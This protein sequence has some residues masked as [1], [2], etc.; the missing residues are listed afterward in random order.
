MNTFI[1]IF[2]RQ[3]SGSVLL[4]ALAF[5][6]ERRNA[7][8][9]LLWLSTKLFLYAPLGY[10]ITLNVTNVGL[11]YTSSTVQ[12]ATANSVP[13]ATFFL[14]VLLRR[15]RSS[16]LDEFVALD[17]GLTLQEAI[18]LRSLSGVAK[19]AG[20][21]LCLAGVLVIAFYTG[22]GIGPVNHHRL[23][24]GG[25]QEH[26]AAENGKGTNWILGTFLMVLST[27]TWSLWTVLM[28]SLLKEYPSTL[29]TTALQCA[30][31][32]V[33]PLPL[34][35]AVERDPAAWRL[36]FDSGLLAI[37]YTG[38][39]ATAVSLYM[40]TWCI[41][42]KGPVFLAMSYPLGFVFTLFCSSFILG[43]V[44]H[45]GSVV[46]GV[47]MV[48]GLYSVLWG[49]SKEND[50]AKLTTVMVSSAV[51]QEET[52]VAPAS[53]RQQQPLQVG[54]VPATMDAKKP[55]VI[56][57]VIQVIFTGQYVVSKAAFDHG[58]NTFIYIFYRQAAASVLLLLLAIILERRNAPPMSLRLFTNIFLYALLGNTISLNVNNMG[59]KYTSS[60]VQAATANSE[61][62]RLRT[63]RGAAK[64]AGVGLCLAGVLVIALYSGPAIS[65]VNHHR[66][67]GGG[68]K[69]G[70]GTKWMLGTFLL[71]LSTATW[72]LWTVLMASLLKEYPSKLMATALQCALSAAQSLPLAAAVEH[73]PAAWRLRFDA[74]LLAVAYSAVFATGVSYYLQAWCIEKKGPVFLAMSY[75]LGFV[76][77]IFCSSFILGEIVHLGSVVGGVLM[78][79]GLYSVLWGKSKEAV[80]ATGYATVE[81]KEVA[82]TASAGDGCNSESDRKLQQGRLASP[83]QQAM[84][85]KMPYIIVIVIELIYTGLYV[86]SK[87]AF[88][89]GMNSFIFIFYRQAASSA[90]LLPLAITL[91]RNTATLNMYNL[92]LKYTSST[93]ASATGN[94]MPVVTFFLALLLR[95]EVIRLRSSSGAAKAAGVGFCLA[96]VLVLALYAGPAINSLNHHHVFGHEASEISG[97]NSAVTTTT[98]TRWVEGTLLMMLSNATWSLWTVLMAS[99]LKEYPSKLLATALQ[100]VISAAQSLLVPAAVERDPAA[101]RLRF[102]AGLLA[103]AYYGVFVTGVSFYLQAWCIEKKGPVFLAMASPLSFVFTILCSSFLLGEIVHLGSIVG[104][105]LMVAGLYS[106]LWGKSKEHKAL[107]L[108]TATSTFAAV[109]KETA[110]APETD[111]SNSDRELKQ[112]R[113]DSPEQQV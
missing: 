16:L 92:G 97:R 75:P 8:P 62:I 13:V 82:A 15:A 18:R 41:E 11:K 51:T 3:A 55:Y 98:R 37:L 34:A 23:V 61:V 105:V 44:V 2:Y 101:W 47:L 54:S 85:A 89:H 28:P 104:G 25:G 43:E 81:A 91:E 1:F 40:H 64:V 68:G 45:L 76:F 88:N 73:D 50:M 31:S 19:A 33:Q 35:A 52:A 57:I 22:P 38:I 96:G 100:C 46:G 4:L 6:L 72:S 87:A 27:V 60:T 80:T 67:F 66:A 83:E 9:M 102:D 110:A 106:V 20:V 84:D 58:M 93:V 14:A 99:L 56:V 86:I 30:L 95:Q 111:T 39:F 48:A 5:I 90:L 10:T 79:A 78:V 32:A 70:K 74:G 26:E 108:T 53:C 109:E 21:A 42:K 17:H 69:S 49:K 107:A 24:S 7:P 12:A 63:L 65:P 29:L 113:L 71:V 59:L 94:S 112:G 103:I 36:R 77:T